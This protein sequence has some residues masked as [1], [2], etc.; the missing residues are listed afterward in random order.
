ML[1]T[2]EQVEAG[3]LGESAPPQGLFAVLSAG[4]RAAISR[5]VTE[6]RMPAG[7]ELWAVGAAADCLA[8]IIAG[9]IELRVDTEFPGKQIVVGVFGAGTV[10][11]A[12]CVVDH[13]PRA[14]T[15][16]ALE[17]TTLLLLTKG[18]FDALAAEHPQIGVKLLK[19][20][21]RA[22]TSRLNQAYA[23]LAS[24]F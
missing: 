12:S 18:N 14:T 24:V 4:E 23:R 8:S 15:A 10:I 22:E 1:S 2:K 19:G 6:F 17:S 13:A 3:C 16:T 9:S 20:L 21:L 5:Y 11:G 7:D